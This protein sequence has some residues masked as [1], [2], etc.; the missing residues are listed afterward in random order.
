MEIKVIKKKLFHKKPY[1]AYKHIVSAHA[2]YDMNLR[3]I[4]K[5]KVGYNLSHK[6]LFATPVKYDY[7]KRP[8]YKRFA[9]NKVLTII[10][11]DNKK[12]CSVRN[13]HTSEILEYFKNYVNNQL[14]SKKFRR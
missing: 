14:Q 8:A 2:V 3:G 5:G 7:R 10:N 9:D 4:S 12:V 13:Y 11:P 6:A 1:K